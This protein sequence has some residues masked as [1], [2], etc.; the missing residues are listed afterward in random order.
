M[1]FQSAVS[2][3][4]RSRVPRT[5]FSV[6]LMSDNLWVN[7]L[8][9]KVEA[10]IL[11][12]ASMIAFFV[13]QLAQAP[14]VVQC[15]PTVPDSWVKWLL[16]T[17]VQTVV[18][19]ASISAGVLIA[20]WS[21][22]A[23]SKRDRE[24]WILDQKKA[25]WRDIIVRITEAEREM[26]IVY[27]SLDEYEHLESAVRNILPCLRGALFIYPRLE[28]SGFVQKWQEFT[29]FVATEFRAGINLHEAAHGRVGV[30]LAEAEATY[31][32]R[33][34]LEH[35]LRNEFHALID[36]IRKF[37]HEDLGIE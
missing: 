12:V 5:A 25:E 20:L 6:W 18:S 3:G 9:Y 27:S 29:V 16:P 35:K 14:V 32:N 26:P 24:R 31:E 2:G 21:F 17:I 15:A 36:Q 4:S 10:M 33:R 22:R 23:T 11:H 13:D 34:A 30:T 28:G 19:L 8:G 7:F 37:A 1:R